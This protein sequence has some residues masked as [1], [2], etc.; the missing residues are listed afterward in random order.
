LKEFWVALCAVLITLRFL[1]AGLSWGTIL[2][3]LDTITE[4]NYG[5]SAL[6]STSHFVD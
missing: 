3:F 6:K 1:V 2:I 4:E 5:F